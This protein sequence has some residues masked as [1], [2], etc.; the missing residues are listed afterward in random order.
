MKAPRYAR[1]QAR[2]DEPRIAPRHAAW[3]SFATFDRQGRPVSSAADCTLR[4]SE[5]L[6]NDADFVA[7]HGSVACRGFTGHTEFTIARRDVQRFVAETEKIRTEAS[8]SALLVAGWEKGDE[9]LRMQIV[10]AGRTGRFTARVRI[11]SSGPRSDPGSSVETEFIVAPEALTTFLRDLAR[12]AVDENAEPAA[13]SGD[14]D[15]VA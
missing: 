3:I 11:A 14:G 6:T 1:R 10:R 4:F 7:L 9:R 8:D 15:A 13:L 12:L 2:I 5:S